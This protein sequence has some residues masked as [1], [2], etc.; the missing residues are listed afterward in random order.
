ME[1]TKARQLSWVFQRMWDLKPRV[2]LANKFF[3]SNKYF[4]LPKEISKMQ[5]RFLEKMEGLGMKVT[6]E[7]GS[8]SQKV[9]YNCICGKESSVRPDVSL[10][11]TWSCCNECS[12]TKKSTSQEKA[13]E[14]FRALGMTLISKY[15]NRDTPLTYICTCG[16]EGK[17][18]MR[19]VLKR[20]LWYGC[21]DCAYKKRQESGKKTCKKKYG[22]EHPMKLPVFEAKRQET[23]MRRYGVSN[24]T[25]LKKVQDKITAT[26]K[27]KTGYDDHPSHNPEH[28]AK[29]LGSCFKKKEFVMPSGKSFICQGYEPITLQ[30]LL[31]SGVKEEDIFNPSKEG[32]AIPYTFEEKTRVYHPDIFVKSELLLV[33]VKSE[34]TYNRCGKDLRKQAENL[35]KLKA[36]RKAGYSTRLYVYNDKGN[37]VSLKE[38]VSHKIFVQTYFIKNQL[39]LQPLIEI[40]HIFSFAQKEKQQQ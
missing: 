7:Y 31:D 26:Y 32:I 30:N 2:V 1:L 35:E 29:N 8:C 23:C 14:N 38:K 39:Y 36:C 22:I 34:W 25:K 5:K 19:C 13:E 4:F 9:S 27:S 3:L 37:L 20:D 40:F 10:S 11:S 33:E 15:V 21:K 24:P 6:G 16:K 18:T 28:V 12:R 17:T